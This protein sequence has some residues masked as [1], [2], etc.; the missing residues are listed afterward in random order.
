MAAMTRAQTVVPVTG[1]PSARMACRTSTTSSRALL[2]QR[3][4]KDRMLARSLMPCPGALEQSSSLIA[5]AVAFITCNAL[6]QSR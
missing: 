6:P 1:V 5:G 4:A 2:T 3:P